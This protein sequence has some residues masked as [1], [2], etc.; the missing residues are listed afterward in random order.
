MKKI[1]TNNVINNATTIKVMANTMGYLPTEYVCEDIEEAL[2][3]LE[4][5]RSQVW[6][7]DIFVNG[8]LMPEA[9]DETFFY[10]SVDAAKNGKVWLE[11]AHAFV[12]EEFKSSFESGCLD[13]EDGTLL[14]E[15]FH[16]HGG[17][18]EYVLNNIYEDIFGYSTITGVDGNAIVWDEDVAHLCEENGYDVCPCGD[19]TIREDGT[20]NE[21]WLIFPN[22]GEEEYAEI[23]YS[24]VDTPE[25]YDHT[26]TVEMEYGRVKAT[27]S[28]GVNER[29][30]HTLSLT[31]DGKTVT[32]R[33][34]DR[35][36]LES[37][38][39]AVA[40][41]VKEGDEYYF[42]GEKLFHNLDHMP[43]D[44]NGIHATGREYLDFNSIW[45]DEYEDDLPTA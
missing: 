4:A 23:L 5:Y 31:L 43:Y 36:H 28:V 38:A 11:E 35:L 29:G 6:D 44:R 10:A 45:R 9:E 12:S 20:P 24:D 34:K 27:V 14:D 32:V 25:W 26:T 15:M 19:H 30:E 33:N 16:E 8:I 13:D 41:G 40:E 3:V 2:R 17:W 37:V 1:N 18:E 7:G 39:E 21:W 42:V 22:V